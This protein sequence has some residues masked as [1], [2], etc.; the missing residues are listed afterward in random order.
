VVPPGCDTFDTA[1]RLLDW[2]R[3]AENSLRVHENARPAVVRITADAVSSSAHFVSRLRRALVQQVP[4]IAEVDLDD[5]PA[6]CVET[7][8]QVA[9]AEGL[10]PVLVITR[11]HAFASIADDHLLSVLSTMRQME[12]DGELTTIAVSP[13][14][15]RLLREQLSEAGL[16]PFVNSAYGDNHDVVVMPPLERAEFVAAAT[17]AGLG[18]REAQALF[19]SAGGPDCVHAAMIRSAVDGDV[20]PVEGAAVRLEGALEGFFDAAIGSRTSDRDDLRLR[21][22][23][24]R[25][26]PAQIAY[27]GHRDLSRFLLKDTR[28]RRGEVASPVLA[29]LL[30]QGREGPWRAYSKVLEAVREERFAE[31][32]RQTDLLDTTTPELKAFAGFLGVLTAIHDSDSGGLLEIDWKKASRV[33]RLLLEGGYPVESHRC[34][35]ED[36]VRWSGH[37]ASAVDAGQG[38]GARLDVL[39]RRAEDPDVR[40]LLVY[41]LSAFLNRVRRAASPGGRVR[42]AASMPESVLQAVA[43]SMGIDPLRAPSE[44]PDLDYQRFFGGLG[45]YRPPVAGAPLD[46]THLLVVV[47]SLLSLRMPKLAEE[48]SMCD[49]AYVRPLHQKLVARM[50]NATAHTYSEIDGRSA[51][52]FLGV[53]RGLLDDAA[54]IW[55]QLGDG[56]VPIEPSSRHLADLLSGRGNE[57]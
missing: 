53:C 30:L 32:S 50:R 39:A 18:P 29:R 45:E 3:V 54:A 19:A 36:L 55:R 7:L 37:V 38:P 11:F 33:G 26:S 1:T 49:P 47:P 35:L 12:H 44:L 56:P 46:L 42:I 20:D 31:A 6:D 40:R 48:L 34:W 22:A 28:E 17:A 16:F 25:L 41:S 5:Y 14:N 10:H 51:D 27:L 43:A 21:I 15:Y 8:V 57:R 13:V 2:V 24:G 23:T 9:Q 52:W 4:A